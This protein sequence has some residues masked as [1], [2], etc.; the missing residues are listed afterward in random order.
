MSLLRVFMG[1]RPEASVPALAGHAAATGAAYAAASGVS[2]RPG[3]ASATGVASNAAGGATYDD[4]YTGDATGATD[5]TASLEAW[6]E[7]RSGQTVA[8]ATNGIY[9]ISRQSNGVGLRIN[10]VNNMRLD[11]RGARLV[12][13]PV[14]S[15]RSGS[16]LS[17]ANGSTTITSATAAFTSADVSDSNGNNRVIVISGVP[18]TIATVV[19][20]TT[21][22]IAYT[23]YAAYNYQG[24]TGT[25]R[26]WFI[27]PAACHGVMRWEGCNNITLNDP[28][29]IGTGARNVGGET[30]GFRWVDADQ[31]EHGIN[32]LAGRDVGQ[33]ST[34]YIN[35]PVMRY[36]AGDG[37]ECNGEVYP[38]PSGPFW[39]PVVT[40]TSP[41]IAYSGRNGLSL[42]AGTTIVS[43]GT[44]AH[45]GLHGVDN[46]PNAADQ[47]A[48]LACT[49][50]GGL[51]IT[52]FDDLPVETGSCAVAAATSFTKV[53]LTVDGCRADCMVI[54]AN[55]H[56]GAITVTNNISDTGTLV[57]GSGYTAI[58]G[59]YYVNVGSRTFSGNSAS[60]AQYNYN[61]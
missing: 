29:V 49:L 7:A 60:M 2:A 22:T 30:S 38:Y 20:S 3:V 59:L 47:A 4:I 34:F 42:D 15:L 26:S 44:I 51:Y 10:G 14:A 50:S 8:L 21:A 57:T 45:S 18:Y 36:L 41:D 9:R 54:R 52:D 33:D 25:G 24:T 23:A 28:Y 43:G 27:R 11:F 19:N 46:E 39:K 48:T 32:I 61:P 5:V 35:R 53:S 55:N 56:S 31:Y 12:L 13:D 6:I 58:D 1:P 17:V 40:I 37:I 16:D